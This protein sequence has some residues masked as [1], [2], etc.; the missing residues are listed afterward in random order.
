M[1]IIIFSEANFKKGKE[2]HCFTFL[3]ISL[4]FD[5]IEDSWILI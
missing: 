1:K 4:M 5:L 2:Y 3:P